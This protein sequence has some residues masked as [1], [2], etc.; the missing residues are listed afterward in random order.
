MNIKKILPFTV[1]SLLLTSCDFSE[2]C[3]RYGNI[4]TYPEFDNI[5]ESIIPLAE[6][7]HL[8]AYGKSDRTIPFSDI[9]NFTQDTL[10][11][12]APQGDYDFI[13]YNGSNPLLNK[14]NYNEVS[15]YSDTIVSDGKTYIS[16]KQEF[17]C[18]QTFSEKLIYQKDIYKSFSPEPFTQTIVL[19]VHTTGNTGPL[20]GLKSELDGIS[21][22][23]YLVSHDKHSTYGTILSEYI[24]GEENLWTST[25]YVFGIN[26][27]ADNILK[28]TTITSD[29][30]ASDYK[31]DLTQYL[32]S[33]DDY[34]ITIDIDLEVGK[35]IEIN[36]PVTI[37]GWV[38]GGIVI[39]K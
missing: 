23:K 19:R 34:R 6:S 24:K 7:R 38:D 20:V 27:T 11:W 30:S 12:S 28:I 1:I 18:T 32:R 13:F 3:I 21:L 17:I 8:L 33:F 16:K 5:E 22:G 36:T 14:Q 2:D 26:N 35:G 31:I 10:R 37:E 39:V 29:S 4:I 9:L 15:L 25:N